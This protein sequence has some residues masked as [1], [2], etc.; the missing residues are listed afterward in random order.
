MYVSVSLDI[1]DKTFPTLSVPRGA[2]QLVGDR[3]VVYV[4]DPADGHRFLERQV[5]LGAASG[6]RVAVLSGLSEGE[7]IVVEGSFF[8][9]AE[10]DRQ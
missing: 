6:D 10:M 2:V 3:S 1:A 4:A 7:Q 9:R 8:L 5:Q